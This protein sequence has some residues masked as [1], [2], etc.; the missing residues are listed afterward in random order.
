MVLSSHGYDV[1]AFEPFRQNL[2]LLALSR[3]LNPDASRRA[4]PRVNDLAALPAHRCRKP[5][6]ENVF[7]APTRGTP[8]RVTVH[9]FGLGSATATCY[10]VGSPPC[11]PA[12][13]RPVR[14][15]PPAR[16]PAAAA[17]AAA[18]EREGQPGRRHHALRRRRRQTAFRGHPGR[19]LAARVLRGQGASRPGRRL[20]QRCAVSPG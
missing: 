3:C 12:H 15:C 6:R 19:L 16:P 1:I 5:I 4:Q 10:L 8:S 14:P 18:D 20:R 11:P 2:N 13:L 9:P 7:R 17:A